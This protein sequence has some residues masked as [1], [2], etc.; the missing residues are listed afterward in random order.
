M[1]DQ[2]P[3]QYAASQG[4]RSMES[5]IGLL[6]SRQKP[7]PSLVDCTNLTDHA[8][9][10][11]RK[12]ISLLDRTGHARFRRGPVHP[13]AESTTP[14]QPPA[15]V[16]APNPIV[17]SPE[18]PAPEP[19]PASFAQPHGNQ[20]LTL[21]FT[22]PN[23]LGPNTKGRKEIGFVKNSFSVTSSSSFLSSAITG[24]CS[25]SNGKQGPSL[26]LV[27]AATPVTS[28]G[29]PPIS[30]VPYR[31][32]C[33]EHDHSEDAS[34]KLSGS[35]NGKCHCSK[36]RKNR[37]R[38]VIRVPAISNKVSEIPADDYSWRKYGQKPI[39]G[40]PY[41]RGYYRCS[42][43]RGCPARKHVER[44]PDDPAMLTVTYDGEHRHSQAASPEAGA[45][46]VV[47]SL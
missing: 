4:L 9:S 27:P 38:K 6:S 39:K 18:P 42:T 28:A 14:R 10:S 1:E 44:A 24:D 36:K 16:L 12:F 20:S 40:S 26:F 35:A 41:P 45:G 34:G 7:Q 21:D 47:N 15:H 2:M 3:I 43:V 13:P 19:S 23:A 30:G 31:K 5:L 8:V 46:L 32:R 17:P 11:F 33:M 29:K 25:V 37:H 22:K